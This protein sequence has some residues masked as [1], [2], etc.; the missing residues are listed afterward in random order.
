MTRSDLW[1]MAEALRGYAVW[2]R[3][4][5]KDPEKYHDPLPMMPNELERMADRTESWADTKAH[6]IMTR[7]EYDAMPLKGWHEVCRDIDNAGNVG[8][9][10][11]S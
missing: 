10:F 5:R 11:L 2:F 8:V 4:H 1:N 3:N 6:R 7:E 9:R